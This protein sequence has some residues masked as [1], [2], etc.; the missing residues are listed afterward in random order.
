MPERTFKYRE[1]RAQETADLNSLNVKL[2]FKGEKKL[3]EE[4]GHR[5]GAKKQ[6]NSVKLG[7]AGKENVTYIII[8]LIHK[9]QLL[10]SV[11]V[12]RLVS[13]SEQST[14]FTV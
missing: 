1:R 4:G 9:N 14:L 11:L 13:Q 7:F 5:Y 6:L 3:T 8:D 12:A 2:G 10:A